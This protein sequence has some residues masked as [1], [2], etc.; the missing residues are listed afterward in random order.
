[1]DT[2]D[3]EHLHENTENGHNW[4]GQEAKHWVNDIGKCDFFF[5]KI[6]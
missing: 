1:M 4:A 6:N 3:Y 5:S 2:S